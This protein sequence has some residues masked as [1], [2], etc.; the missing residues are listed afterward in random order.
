MEENGGA[1]WGVRLA[2]RALSTRWLV[3]A[4]IWL[5][6]ARLGVLFGSRLLMLEH[7]GRISGEPRYVVLEVVDRSDGGYT[8]AAG[9]GERTQW[10]RNLDAHPHAHVSI[11]SRTR[12][13]VVAQRLTPTEA[14]EAIRRYAARHPR[15]WT[16]LAPV[17]ER[18]LGAP[19][20]ESGTTLPLVR[21]AVK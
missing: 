8:V 13:P 15:A 14:A 16:R 7:I 4:P 17:F 3:R 21:L 12:V 18:T 11:G 2:G 20:T 19:I 5:Y 9:F 6:R 10:L 1:T